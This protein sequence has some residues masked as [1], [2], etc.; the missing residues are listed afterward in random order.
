M[1][2]LI[3]RPEKPEEYREMEELVR[4]AFWD[5]YSPGCCEHLIVHNMRVSPAAVPS[6]CL[7]AEIGGKLAGAIWYARAVVRGDRKSTV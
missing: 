2:G 5:R 4:S 6:L 1:N 7:A 3:I